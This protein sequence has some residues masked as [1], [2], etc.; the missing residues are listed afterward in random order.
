MN[1]IQSEL[2]TLRT[3]LAEALARTQEQT[4]NAQYLIVMRKAIKEMMTHLETAMRGDKQPYGE[5]LGQ[6]ASRILTPFDRAF[7]RDEVN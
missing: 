6:Q 4:N 3:K 5:H 7:P 2:P 1:N